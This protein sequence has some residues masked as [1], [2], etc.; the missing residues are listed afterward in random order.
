MLTSYSGGNFLPPWAPRD[1]RHPA[2]PG[3]PFLMTRFFFE[4]QGTVVLDSLLRS[5]SPFY[6]PSEDSLLLTILFFCALTICEKAF[7]PPSFL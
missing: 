3:A 5:A 7:E 1:R 2:F 6:F 4:E